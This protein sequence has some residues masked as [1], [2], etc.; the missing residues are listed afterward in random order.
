[1]N[2]KLPISES[3]PIKARCYDYDRFTYPWHFHSQYEIICVR[4]SHGLCFVG[5]CI[6]KFSAGDVILF[7]TNL[8][9]YMRSDDIYGSAETTSRVQGTIIQF[10]QN[11][12]QYSFDHYPQF[13][14]IKMLLEESERGIIFP[15]QNTTKIGELI[16]GFP[17]LSGF[18]QI[19]GLLELLQELA[20]TS[21]RRSLASPHYYRKFPAM[22]NKRIDK[23][24]SFVNNNYTRNL[25]LQEIASMASMNTSAFCRYFKENTGKTLLQYVMEMRV[26]Y[27]CKLLEVGGMDISQIAVECGFESITHFNRTFKQL[28]NLTPTQYR[29]NIMR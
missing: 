21:E 26:G 13:H 3:N 11:F 4:E 10:E 18:Y 1:M 25:R 29:N 2:E 17:L 15:S 14:Q 16:S 19:S 22:G 5:D 9:H 20:T 27:A 12:M 28:T 6:E 8:P 7:G 24:I 23:I